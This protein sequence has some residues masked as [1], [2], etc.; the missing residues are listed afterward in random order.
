MGELNRNC[1]TVEELSSK[2]E[3]RFEESNSPRQT[4]RWNI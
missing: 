3:E 1:D 2:L 4:K